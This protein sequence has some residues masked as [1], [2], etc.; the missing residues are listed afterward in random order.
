[1]FLPQVRRNGF[2]MRA[3]RRRKDRYHLTVHRADPRDP[4]R[5]MTK[6]PHII[7][8]GVDAE[9]MARARKLAEKM[10]HT[11]DG[12][13]VSDVTVAL[14]LLT[15]GAIHQH[16][17]GAAKACELVKAVHY[18]E[19]RFLETVYGFGLDLQ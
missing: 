4:N 3:L 10:A 1:M 17:D 12:E 18:L 19:E 2:S 9:P 7:A 11:L 14:A 5:A 15:S 16:A 6:P 8:A 13:S